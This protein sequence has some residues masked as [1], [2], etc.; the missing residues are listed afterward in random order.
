MISHRYCDASSE[1]G[2]PNTSGIDTVATWVVRMAL[3]INAAL[4]RRSITD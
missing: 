2:L 3:P 1:V 4:A